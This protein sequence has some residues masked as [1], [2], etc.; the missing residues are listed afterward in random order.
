M[1]LNLVSNAVKY[2]RHGGRIR[3]AC[4][5]A[6]PGRVAIVVEDDGDGIPAD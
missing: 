2:N 5:S 4:R 3:V 6:D 1:L